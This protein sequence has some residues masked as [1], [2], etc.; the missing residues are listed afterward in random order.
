MRPSVRLSYLFNRRLNL[1]SSIITDFVLTGSDAVDKFGGR[2]PS[3]TAAQVKK[4]LSGVSV[5]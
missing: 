4:L 3:A 1:M 2:N 5:S